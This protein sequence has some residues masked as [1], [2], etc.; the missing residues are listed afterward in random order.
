MSENIRIAVA[1]PLTGTAAAFGVQIS[2][3]ART[4]IEQ[5]NEH[6]SI[7]DG[8]KL[9]YVEFDDGGDAEKAVEIA[10]Q[11][12]SQGFQFVVGHPTT[13][14][15][16]PA[17]EIYSK[18]GVLVVT[19][20]CTSPDLTTRGLSNV[21]R[22]FGSNE[23]QATLLANFLSDKFQGKAIALVND[24]SSY[25]AGLTALVT[26]KLGPLGVNTVS[27]GGV[28]RGESDFRSLVTKIT[29]DKAEV[30]FYGGLYPEGALL[31]HQ[32]FEA[33]PGIAF[34]SG[35]GIATSEFHKI[36]GEGV[37]E[38]YASQPEDRSHQPIALFAVKGM[39]DRDF[40]VDGYM[41]HGYVAVQTIVAGIFMGKGIDSAKAY[42]ALR[43]QGNVD[44]IIGNLSWE[45][46]GNV[47]EPP[48][49]GMYRKQFGQPDILIP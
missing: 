22:V 7:F 9:E 43:D 40:T 12:V 18:N 28:T 19:P 25:G 20:G 38:V 15:C 31:A 14:C 39:Q 26:K 3:G 8:K 21:L 16:P 49:F 17:S 45:K 37:R 23:H 29:N 44:S 48:K 32:L 46:T 35:D 36:A 1:G 34:V 10:N 33:G 4:A 47:I 5:Y 2:A 42:Q 11:I 30:V 6:G 24:E 41:L 13:E 27:Y